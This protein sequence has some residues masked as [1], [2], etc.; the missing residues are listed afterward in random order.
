[1]NSKVLIFLAGVGLAVVG[2][3]IYTSDMGFSHEKGLSQPVPLQEALPLS[4]KMPGVSAESLKG[5][6]TLVCFFASWCGP[7]HMNH[8]FIK[9]LAEQSVVRLVG[10]NLR[11]NPFQAQLWL[12]QNGNPYSAIGRDEDGIVAQACGDKGIPTMFLVDKK[13]M[14]RHSFL[15]PL[16]LKKIEKELLPK[17]LELKAEN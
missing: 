11:D 4:S 5:E 13:G 16:S 2:A 14:I 10:I 7:C 9:D 17:V 1:M 6:V 15:G 3:F 12:S 8:N